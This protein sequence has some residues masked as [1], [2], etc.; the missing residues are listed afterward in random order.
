M[1]QKKYFFCYS[2]KLKKFLSELNIRY[3][4]SANNTKTNKP[5]WV[6]IRTNDLLNALTKWKELNNY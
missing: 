1:E 3:E 4:L 2:Y 5:Y 6:Y